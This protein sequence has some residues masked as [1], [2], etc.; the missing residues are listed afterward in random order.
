M[1]S[2]STGDDLSD[3]KLRRY[4]YKYDDREMWKQ[5]FLLIHAI[6]EKRLKKIAQD[7]KKDVHILRPH[8]NKG[9]KPNHAL[10]FDDIKLEFYF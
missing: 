8:E 4:A 1:K 6:C 7:L 2:K 9:R 3:K 5:A 10:K